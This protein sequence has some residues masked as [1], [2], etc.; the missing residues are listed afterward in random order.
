MPNMLSAGASSV[1]SGLCLF[2]SMARESAFLSV[3]VCLDR[4]IR[5]CFSLDASCVCRRCLVHLLQYEDVINRRGNMLEVAMAG[6]KLLLFALLL[7]SE[8]V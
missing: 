6:K 2:F 4:V 7:A 8:L 3:L 1:G 5:G